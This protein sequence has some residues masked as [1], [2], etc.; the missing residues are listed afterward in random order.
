MDRFNKYQ[1]AMLDAALDYAARGWAVIPVSRSKV[2]I[3]ANG[4]R[5]ATKDSEQI[6]AWW[7]EYPNA[8]IGIATGAIS[9]IWVVDIDMKNGKNGISA[10]E[11]RFGDQYV[12]QENTLAQKTPTGGYH[13]VYAWDSEREVHNAQDIVEGVDIRGDGGFIVAAPSSFKV[14]TEWIA[15]QWNENNNAPTQAPDWAWELTE[16][17]EA[18]RSQP[19]DFNKALGGIDQGGR[20]NDLFR[21]ACML[22]SREVSQPTAITFIEILAERCN[23][24]F[25]VVEARSKVERAYTV[26]ENDEAESAIERIKRRRAAQK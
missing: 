25:D 15:Y 17:A 14:G 19:V 22:R 20:D 11:Q 13:L 4:S 5:G 6:R 10:L 21:I 9:G 1:K 2:P 24:P 26:Y 8:Q 3:N 7:S 16:K 12:L 23:P 18:K